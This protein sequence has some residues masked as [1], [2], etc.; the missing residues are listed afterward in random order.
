MANNI[1]FQPMG[2]TYAIAANA[3]NQTV[4]INADSP[5]NQLHVFNDGAAAI[6]GFVRFSSAN[7]NN[8][9]VSVAGTP[10]YGFP[11]H[12]Q[13]EKV[14]T[15]PQAYSAGNATLYV[16]VILASGTGNVYITP[17]EGL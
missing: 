7:G 10:A 2:K 8:A 14:F 6:S 13:Q 4:S 1:P 17:G 11:V 9:A 12:G 16:S 3:A 5:C 15:V